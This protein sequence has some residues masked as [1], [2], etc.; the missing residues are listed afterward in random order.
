[1]P[2]SETYCRHIRPAFL[3]FQKES[4]SS[5]RERIL[6]R[7]GS[8]RPSQVCPVSDY[9]VCPVSSMPSLSGT[10]AWATPF[11]PLARALTAG[12][13]FRD[14]TR[15]VPCS[16]LF[17][18]FALVVFY[19]VVHCPP[20]RVEPICVVML[21]NNKN[22]SSDFE[23]GVTACWRACVPT[24]ELCASAGSTQPRSPD[25]PTARQTDSPAGTCTRRAVVFCTYMLVGAIPLSFKYPQT[26]TGKFRSKVEISKVVKPCTS[27]TPPPPVFWISIYLI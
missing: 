2:T 13:T 27:R 21:Q 24:R 23:N 12:G 17:C 3:H 22:S 1:M 7:D 14:L 20:V 5:K 11:V 10:T 19:S 25:S 6:H 18:G 15:V 8:G 4:N 16:V 26:N 9:Q